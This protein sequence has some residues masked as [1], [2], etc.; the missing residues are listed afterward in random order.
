MQRTQWLDSG[1]PLKKYEHVIFPESLHLDDYVYTKCEISGR[2]G[3]LG[4]K[5]LFG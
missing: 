5:A 2:N 3:L 4:G 1:I